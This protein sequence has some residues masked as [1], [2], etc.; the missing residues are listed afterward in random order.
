VPR[1]SLLT[2]AERIALLAVSLTEDEMIRHYTFSEA[3]LAVIRQHRGGQNR[4]GFAVQLCVLSYPGCALSPDAQAPQVLL[5]FVARQLRVEPEMWSQYAQR[6]ETRREHLLEL[7]AWLALTPFSVTHFR[8]FVEHFTDMACQTERGIVLAN[9]LLEALRRE[10]VIVR[11]VEVTERVCVQ[12]LTQGT[13]KVYEALTASLT[14]AHQQRLDELLTVRENATS[15]SLAWLRQP[16]GTP[17]AKHILIHIERL[18]AIRSLEL[19][20]GLERNVHQNRLLKLATEGSQMTAQHL[21]DLEPL[22]RYATC[23]SE[24][25]CLL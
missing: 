13:R 18:R 9:A 10:H 21:R 15:S 16:A 14:A 17:I 19:P 4:L 23:P 6:A 8:H 24:P 2:S 20:E 11:A 22:R 12:A 1:R 25:L 5:A 7:Q 3:D